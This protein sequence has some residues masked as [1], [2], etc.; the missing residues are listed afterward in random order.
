M[1]KDLT[2]KYLR[3][4]LLEMDYTPRDISKIIYNLKKKLYNHS[5]PV[6]TYKNS[7]TPPSFEI[8]G[9]TVFRKFYDVK[10]SDLNFNDVK[11][12]TRITNALGRSARI[13]FLGDFF[14]KDETTRK[15]IGI[16][17]IGAGARKE[18]LRVLK[19]TVGGN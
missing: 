5:E 7:K 1:H 16:T 9:V 13:I 10:I 14:I 12:A 6:P 11:T 19:Q 4:T 2:I 18:F 3:E 8:M 17:N 15:L